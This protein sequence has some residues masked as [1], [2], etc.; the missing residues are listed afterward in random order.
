MYLS[1]LAGHQRVYEGKWVHSTLCVNP[2]KFTHSADSLYTVPDHLWFVT[3]L[4]YPSSVKVAMVSAL[5]KDVWQLLS[6]IL[7]E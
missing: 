4:V 1:N 3:L 7:S 5:Y 6:L 2:P